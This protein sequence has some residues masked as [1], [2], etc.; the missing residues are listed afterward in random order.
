MVSR[1]NQQNLIGVVPATPPGAVMEVQV[2]TNL[3]PRNL[4]GVTRPRADFI[5]N[6]LGNRSRIPLRPTLR[7]VVD[8]GGAED[9][10]CTIRAQRLAGLARHMTCPFA[11][12]TPLEQDSKSRASSRSSGERALHERDDSLRKGQAPT[13][14]RPKRPEPLFQERALRCCGLDPDS[15]PNRFALCFCQLHLQL[16]AAQFVRLLQALRLSLGVARGRARRQDG[17]GPVELPRR[18]RLP[19]PRLL[20]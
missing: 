4:A 15:A 19:D 5:L 6:C 3:T 13:P 7:S 16:P 17:L 8:L 20:R 9:F 11:I 12:W 1:A 18:E 14:L 2:V 10:L